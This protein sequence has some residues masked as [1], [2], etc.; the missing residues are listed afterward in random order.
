MRR[1]SF[2]IYSCPKDAFSNKLMIIMEK[3]KEL[4][5][6]YNE[7]PN[8]E[9]E[10]FLMLRI[11]FLRFSRE[12]LIEMVSAL[13]PIIFAE[14]VNIT[15]NKRKNT[16]LELNNSGYKLI[17]LLSVANMDEFCL[18]QWIFFLDTFKIEDLDIDEENSELNRLL[19][20]NDRAFKPY[21]MGMVKHWDECR[22][23]IEKYNE[24]K[25]EEF[26]KRTIMIHTQKLV[27]QD[28]LASMIAKIFVYVGIMNNF[29]NTIDLDIIE[30]VIEKDFLIAY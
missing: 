10:I 20:S 4:I 5:T 9:S 29:R 13:W 30:E 24:R 8:L 21:A 28:Q 18:Y 2:I 22:D 7:N 6:K 11:M 26:E 19:H 15:N 14:I 12:N 1:L 3:I 23:L 17:E 27:S 16:S 25:F